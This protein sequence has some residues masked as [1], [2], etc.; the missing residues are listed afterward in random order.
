MAKS[1][2][3][4]ESEDDEPGDYSGI[5][6][7]KDRVLIGTIEPVIINGKKHLARIDTGATRSAICETLVGSLKLGPVIRRV[8]IESANG[9]STRDVIGAEIILAGKKIKSTFTVSNRRHMN[10]DI[11][12]GRNILKRG[13]L[14][15]PSR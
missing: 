2:R 10:F 6:N 12:I 15:D 9:N 14:I 5:L 4:S 1:K 8:N 7:L 3:M 13:F 11:L